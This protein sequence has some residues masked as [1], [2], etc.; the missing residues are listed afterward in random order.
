MGICH[1][2][3]QAY[4]LALTCLEGAVKIR[5]YR[6]GRLTDSDEIVELYGE[7]VAL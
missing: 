2:S 4:D 5:K 6:V 1:Y 3:H 7:E